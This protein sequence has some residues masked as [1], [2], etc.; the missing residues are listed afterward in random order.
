MTSQHLILAGGFPRAPV[1]TFLR[2][3]PWENVFG[4]L[5]G[6]L[7]QEH[8]RIRQEEKLHLPRGVVV[9]FRGGEPAAG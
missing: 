3:S 2:L 6:W 1:D 4:L 7:G 5:H 8:I 9:S